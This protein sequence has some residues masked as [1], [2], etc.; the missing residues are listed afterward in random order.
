M[1]QISSSATI[2]IVFFFV[3]QPAGFEEFFHG[4]VTRYSRRAEI[5]QSSLFSLVEECEMFSRG[6]EGGLRFEE[7]FV[8]EVAKGGIVQGMKVFRSLKAPRSE[9][10]WRWLIQIWHPFQIN[11]SFNSCCIQDAGYRTTTMMLHIIIH[12]IKKFNRRPQRRSYPVSMSKGDHDV[13]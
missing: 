4:N 10:I 1:E 3:W 11:P 5:F 9:L 8:P 12:R 6:R 2:F 13:H 7:F